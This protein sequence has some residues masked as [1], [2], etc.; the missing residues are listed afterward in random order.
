MEDKND[1]LEGRRDHHNTE[2]GTDDPLELFEL[3]CISDHL[4]DG[5]L[6]LAFL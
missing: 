5:D 3:S 2:H 1:Y 4:I 6:L